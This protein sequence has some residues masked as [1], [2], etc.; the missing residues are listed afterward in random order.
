MSG[1]S[2]Y[3]TKCLFIGFEAVRLW[4]FDRLQEVKFVLLVTGSSFPESMNSF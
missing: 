4:R 2:H 3:Y 1:H